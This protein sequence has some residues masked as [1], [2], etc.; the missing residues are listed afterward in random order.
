MWFGSEDMIAP[1]EIM[2][3]SAVFLL[4][5]P[6]AQAL[7][8]GKP[9]VPTPEPPPTAKPETPTPEPG[10]GPTATPT[11]ILP[12]A[13]RTLR[14]VGTIPPEL[15]NRL[16]TKILPKLRA[17][18]SELKIGLDFA[19]TVPAEAAGTLAADLRQILQ[20]LGIGDALKVD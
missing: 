16:G 11:P 13:M 4:R 15:W 8:S 2:F 18:N 7:R 9:T 14:L 12:E 6:T 1:D 10:G 3:E 5:K 20:E 17:A 19:V